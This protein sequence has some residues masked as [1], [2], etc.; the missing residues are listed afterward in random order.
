M[1]TLCL[2]CPIALN[3]T[4]PWVNMLLADV[5]P[6]QLEELTIEVRLLGCLNGLNWARTESLLLRDSFK[7]LKTVSVKIAVWH[8]AN[9]RSQ[10][11]KAFMRDC[12]PTLHSRG[13][14]RLVD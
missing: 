5:N 6:T 9:Q 2:R 13:M 8:T 7:E 14:L 3:S 10:D 1:R 4:V 11:I 12:L